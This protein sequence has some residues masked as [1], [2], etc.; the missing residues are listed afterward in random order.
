MYTDSN[1]GSLG[2]HRQKLPEY[3][4]LLS[5]ESIQAVSYTHLAAA[6]QS[7]PAQDP[8]QRPAPQ[9]KTEP[10]ADSEFNLDD[11]LNEFK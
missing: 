3:K 10:A 4:C 8:A 1:E 2:F 9:V 7:A 11:I 6:P 5:S